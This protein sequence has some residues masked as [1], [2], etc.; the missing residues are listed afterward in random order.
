MSDEERRKETYERIKK[1]LGDYRYRSAFLTLGAVVC[2]LLFIFSLFPLVPAFIAASLGLAQ[3]DWSILLW[4]ACIAVF[5]VLFWIFQRFSRKIE[6]KRGITLE[7]KMYVPA[8]EALCHFREYSFPNHPIRGSKLKAERRMQY[9]L[10]LL[11]EIALPNVTIVR[12]EA[13]QLWQLGNNLKTR[14]IPSMRRDN[15][16]VHSLLIA[17]VDYLSRPELPSLTALN[18][19]IAPLPEIVERNIYLDARSAF[20]KRSNLRHTV[21]FSVFAIFGWF[22]YYVDINYLGATM[23]AAF[24]LGLMSL[25]G[26]AAIYVAYLG[27]TTRKELRT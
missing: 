14:L 12:E 1:R 24:Q 11:G 8:Y 9:I 19:T 6:E 10:T 5:G 25:L 17:L 18:K 2:A 23:S 13:I 15:G 20:F 16:N 26:I 4:F 3:Y 22:V 27:L 21:V 7:E